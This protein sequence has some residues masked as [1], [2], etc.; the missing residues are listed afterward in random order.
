[1]ANP[2][3]RVVSI[4]YG[5]CVETVRRVILFMEILWSIGLQIVWSVHEDKY[6]KLNHQTISILILP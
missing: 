1:M 6:G 2:M 3:T 5:P 4:S